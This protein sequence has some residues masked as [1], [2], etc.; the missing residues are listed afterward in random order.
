MAGG[1]YRS[2]ALAAWTESVADS[3][4]WAYCA[5]SAP[6]QVVDYREHFNQIQEG[7]PRN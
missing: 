2:C 6:V 1:S 3:T 4:L 7:I 5:S